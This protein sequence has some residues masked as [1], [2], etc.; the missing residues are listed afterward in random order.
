MGGA[1]EHGHQQR[2]G[3][4]I[5]CQ[6]QL[7][8][9]K[10]GG[11]VVGSGWAWLRGQGGRWSRGLDGAGSW[12]PGWHEITS[13]KLE[14]QYKK[15]YERCSSPSCGAL[16]ANRPCERGP[17]PHP[18]AEAPAPAK[19]WHQPPPRS[20]GLAPLSK[21]WALRAEQRE[22]AI[23]STVQHERR[24]RVLLALGAVCAG[25][26]LPLPFSHAAQ[27]HTIRQT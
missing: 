13:R 25:A 10:A 3:Q 20:A 27:H 26:A 12:G 1:H 9:G 6:R 18:P 2:P 8:V 17:D 24:Y 7:Q 19:S 21:Q 16:R 14:N 23:A 15:P 4:E 5:K 11:R 22:R